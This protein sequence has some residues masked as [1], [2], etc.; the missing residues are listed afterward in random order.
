MVI[1]EED[2]FTRILRF[3]F[4][5]E[6]LVIVMVIVPIL[7]FLSL[8]SPIVAP[9]KCILQEALAEICRSQKCMNAFSH[10][11]LDWTVS[12]EHDDVAPLPLSSCLT[13]GQ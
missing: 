10:C 1:S 3:P 8:T 11:A 6:L 9:L 5:S 2:D 7:L 12:C 4:Q 13:D